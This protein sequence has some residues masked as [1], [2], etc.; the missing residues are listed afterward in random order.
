MPEILLNGSPEYAKNILTDIEWTIL[1]SKEFR[2]A[3]PEMR[4]QGLEFLALTS[5]SSQSKDMVNIGQIPKAELPES[6]KAVSLAAWLAHTF[7]SGTILALEEVE[8]R[9]EETMAYWLCIVNDGQVVIGT[10]TL[11]ED[12]ETVVTMAES[13]LEALGADN[14]GYIGEAARNLPFN[15]DAR[16]CP[17]LAEAL[18]KS[19]HQKAIIKRTS[20]SNLTTILTVG[21]LVSFV[22]AGGAWYGIMYGL[23]GAETAEQAEKRRDLQRKRAQNEFQ[24]ILN[25][26]GGMNAAGHTLA[27]IW[28]SP[29]KDTPTQID[30]WNL[31]SAVCAESS[32][33][34][35]YL[36]SN[37]T[38]PADIKATI[39]GWCDQ[40]AIS[41][42]GTT[43]ECDIQYVGKPMIVS[44]EPSGQIYETDINEALLD[45]SEIDRFQG[46]L[47]KIARLGPGTAYAI[48]EPAE[49]PFRG[50]R[51]L[52]LV[53]MWNQGEWG[54]TFPARYWSAVT[55][56]LRSFN[57]IAVKT[58]SINWG[59]QVV[60]LNGLYIAK[61]E[62]IE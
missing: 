10:D 58:V 11:I 39:G 38:L 28:I 46:E 40:L 3:K 1:G 62:G 23:D 8:Q 37:L 42:D 14:V 56:M 61:K 36:N 59:A 30:G 51:F 16:D 25:E 31:Q 44:Q 29:I 41:A 18:T 17:V 53:E 60:E 27:S 43:A 35:T 33:K 12:W 20:N 55:S 24:T 2:K 9:R 6:G 50:S 45:Q 54:L 47:M 15:T 26:T 52:P 49:Y 4:T 22:A 13:T 32:C 21:L 7:R 5:T 19:A 34:L 48:N 57:G